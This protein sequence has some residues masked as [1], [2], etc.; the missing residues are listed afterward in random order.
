MMIGLVKTAFVGTNL[1]PKQLSE[2]YLTCP[3]SEITAYE[4]KYAFV[5]Q[6]KSAVQEFIELNYADKE[7]ASSGLYYIKIDELIDELKAFEAKDIT[8]EI[9]E[10]LNSL[11]TDKQKQ[12]IESVKEKMSVLNKGISILLI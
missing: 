8:A 10:K 4:C 7:M 11:L 12:E 3:D 9:Q 2:L 6:D 5:V 1:S